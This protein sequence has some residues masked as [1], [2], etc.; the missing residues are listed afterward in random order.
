MEISLD[1]GAAVA[2]ELKQMAL[3][4]ADYWPSELTF[5]A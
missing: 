5:H 4:A 1:A 3:A 2:A